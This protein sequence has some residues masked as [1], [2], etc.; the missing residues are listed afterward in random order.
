MY[1][2]IEK[3]Q[4]GYNNNFFCTALGSQY[5]HGWTLISLETSKQKILLHKRSIQ[6]SAMNL[7]ALNLEY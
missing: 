2:V 5:P 4:F 3:T 7:R 6:V 1:E